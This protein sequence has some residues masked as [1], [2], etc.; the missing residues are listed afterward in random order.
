[1]SINVK[2]IVFGIKYVRS[3]RVPDIAG[4]IVDDVLRE[5]KSPFDD[6]YFPRVAQNEH[7]ARVLYS[8]DHSD[9]FSIGR[10]DIVV[11]LT[12]DD[13]EK[14]TKKINRILEYIVH[15][16]TK[17]EIKRIQRF[18]VIFRYELK[19]KKAIHKKIKELSGSQIADP[20]DL[21]I[22]FSKKL[23]T[24]KGYAVRGKDDYR[25]S[26]YTFEISNSDESY[27]DVDYQYY[28]GPI[29][30]DVRETKPSLSEFFE[31]AKTFM[32]QECSWL[33]K[34]TTKENG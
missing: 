19:D 7:G 20:N 32:R 12:I 13:F 27:V 5:K 8:D 26:I 24:L 1:M 9:R 17:Y 11:S 30:E 25:N 18:G 21:I 2:N 31:S 23:R 3:F 28:F 22:R 33:E 16:I 6:K 14:A 15:I 29:V 10:D 4:E 34:Y